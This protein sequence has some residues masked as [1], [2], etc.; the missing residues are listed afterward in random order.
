MNLQTTLLNAFEKD[1]AQ[2][3]KSTLQCSVY[4]FCIPAY[5]QM[6][7]FFCACVTYATPS[8]LYILR[9]LIHCQIPDTNYTLMMTFG[10]GYP[11]TI[12]KGLL[13][14]LHFLFE[15][16]QLTIICITA[17]SIDC[18]FSFYSFLFCSN[19]TALS[20]ILTNSQPKHKFMDLIHKSLKKHN[21]LIECLKCLVHIYGPI[22][23][24]HIVTNSIQMCVFTYLLM[25]RK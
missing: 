24:L 6:V 19:L 15:L 11:W 23:F 4:K 14:H 16:L 18:F 20:G 3:P 7:S 9:Q 2:R 17:I 21:E 25:V 8:T 12:P 1:L 13:Y 5:I 10:H 22:A